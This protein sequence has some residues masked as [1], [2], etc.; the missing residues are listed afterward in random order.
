VVGLYAVRYCG[1][2]LGA[3]G[4]AEWQLVIASLNDQLQTSPA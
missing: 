3:S 4:P 2:T 1:L